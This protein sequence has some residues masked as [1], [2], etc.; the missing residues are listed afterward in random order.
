MPIGF[1]AY[2]KD[3]NGEY[4]LFTGNMIASLIAEYT[5]SQSKLQDN[6]PKDGYVIKT[7]VTTTLLNSITGNYGVKLFEVLP[8]FK[9]IGRK[10][11]ET[12]ESNSGTFL[13][14]Y[15]ESYGYLVGAETKEK[16]AVVC[17]MVFCEALAYCKSK[18]ITLWDYMVS[19][20]EKYGYY[21]E[22]I[23]NVAFTGVEGQMK[24]KDIM[25]YL[26]ANPLNEIA[27]YKVKFIRN[28]KNDTILNVDTNKVMPTGLANSNIIYYD[29][30]DNAWI[31]IRPSGTEPKIKFYYGLKGSSFDDTSARAAKFET[32]LRNEPLQYVI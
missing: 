5:L 15:E 28:Y 17:A 25:E 30:E 21:K 12:E 20:Y 26:S 18:G 27:G 29:L 23:I 13:S 22:S 8:G 1:G 7:I 2:V 3:S 24:M 9:W 6:L 11:R 16:D 4:H 19:I 10:M 14:G 31:C 32:W